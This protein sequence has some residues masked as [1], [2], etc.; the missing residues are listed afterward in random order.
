MSAKNQSA[1]PRPFLGEVRIPQTPRLRLRLYTEVIEERL[2]EL[3]WDKT[4]LAEQM[5]K[6]FPE[7]GI[8]VEQIY[9][10]LERPR[11]MSAWFAKAMEWT[12]GMNLPPH[13][14]YN[15]TKRA[16]R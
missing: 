11:G 4:D 10:A 14:H 12:L 16:K 5:E 2:E 9:E 3:L 15:A 13:C 8:K 7:F 6:N 1:N